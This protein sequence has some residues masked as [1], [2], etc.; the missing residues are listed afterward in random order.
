MNLLVVIH[1]L[2][3]GGAE[4]V[5]ANLVNHWAEK[6][7]KI[8]VVTL[9]SRDQDFYGLHSAVRRVTLDMAS[10]SRNPVSAV[11]NNLRRVSALRRVLRDVRPDAAVGMMPSAG[12]LLVLAAMFIPKIATIASERIYPPM[13]PLGAMWHRLRK[14]TYP[15]AT[16]VAMLTSEG[17]EWLSAEIPKAR[18]VVMPNPIP[19]PL[20]VS[21]PRLNPE[22]LIEPNRK[23]LLAVGR[24]D[25]QKGFD[26]LLTAF[27]NLAPA[28]PSWD[29]V[30]LGEGPLRQVLE[31]QVRSLELNGRA[32]LP[33]RA[34]NIGDWY[35]RADFYVMSSRYEGFPNSL[36]EAMAHGCA[37]VSFDCDTG[38]RDIVR[39]DVD[40]LL[41][42]RGDVA[43][44]GSALGLLMS[45]DA[46][47][48]RLANRATEV[49]ERF[50][51]ERIAGM[52]E[53]LL[54]EVVR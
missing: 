46:L 5:T 52:W 37:A 3:S 9:A 42:P 54:A 1:S 17:L 28:N 13:M 48:Q 24:L 38:P 29:L 26:L 12:I 8:S 4:R 22:S 35:R 51:I 27:A 11:F 15:R 16:Q 43:A 2:H 21:E 7:W 25:Q 47:R 20:P 19:Y 32:Y 36:G 39:H 49:R 31:S 41:V 30:I 44:L 45:N 23:L 40:G 50:S 34:G 10:E 6:G 33:G 14:W 18:G 53:G